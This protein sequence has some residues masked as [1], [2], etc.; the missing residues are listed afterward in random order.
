M[1]VLKKR[2]GGTRKWPIREC[3]PGERKILSFPKTAELLRLLLSLT[4]TK[5]VQ[6][7]SNVF[8]I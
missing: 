8:Q 4:Q 5:S 6:L 2:P 3:P 7:T 1:L